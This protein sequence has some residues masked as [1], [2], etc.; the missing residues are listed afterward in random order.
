M[1]FHHSRQ[2][3]AQP[4]FATR[5]DENS[6]RETTADLADPSP[7]PERIAGARQAVAQLEAAMAE[8][9]LAQREVLLLTAIAGLKLHE[10]AE[11]LGLPLNTVKTQL[12][13]ARLALAKALAPLDLSAIGVV[14]SRKDESDDDL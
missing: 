6:P 1:D 4:L 8:L 12:R 13:R 7:D 2:H 3:S 10:V 9:P 11:A 14:T 5:R